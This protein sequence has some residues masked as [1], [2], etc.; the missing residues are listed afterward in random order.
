M[1][2]VKGRDAFSKLM[3]HQYAHELANHVLES[4]VV[5]NTT[6]PTRP[7]TEISRAKE[8]IPL[9]ERIGFALIGWTVQKGSR[10]LA[11]CCPSS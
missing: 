11:A 3:M 9:G 8:S 2:N 1:T 6:H 7:A 4:G 5:V 10:N